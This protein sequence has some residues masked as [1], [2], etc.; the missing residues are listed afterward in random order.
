M[1][2]HSVEVTADR[3][4]RTARLI[5]RPYTLDDMS[6][7]FDLFSREDVCRYLPWAPLDLEQAR[8]KLDQRILQTTIGP[9]RDAIIPI[10]IEAATG[11]AVG[12]FMLRVR[13]GD[14][15]QGEVGWSVHPDFQGRGFATE[16]ARE[17]LRVGFEDLGLHRIYAEADPRNLGSLKVMKRL[18]MRH[19]GHLVENM[20]LKGEWVGEAIYAMLESEWR[21]SGG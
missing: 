19:E 7:L 3:P 8:A 5:L 18:G 9:E 21:G 10:A 13:S 1:L 15:R 11:L 20:F 14:D 12:E 17:M 2:E 4:L 6:S 16:A